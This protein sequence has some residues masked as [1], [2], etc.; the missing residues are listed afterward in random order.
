MRP[1]SLFEVTAMSERIEVTAASR[2][3]AKEIVWRFLGDH[4]RTTLLRTRL[5]IAEFGF[6]RA[7]NPNHPLYQSVA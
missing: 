1:N 5:R 3:E 4:N 6:K 7:P 2:K